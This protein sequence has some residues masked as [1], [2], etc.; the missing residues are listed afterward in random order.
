MVVSRI[1][2]FKATPPNGGEKQVETFYA[3]PDCPKDL[4]IWKKRKQLEHESFT[5]IEFVSSKIAD[6][7]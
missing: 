3:I 4:S 6:H 7:D 5:E 2:K 1:I